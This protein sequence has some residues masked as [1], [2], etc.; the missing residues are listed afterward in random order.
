MLTRLLG[1]L[2]VVLGCFFA[3]YVFKGNR[4]DVMCRIYGWYFAKMIR[5]RPEKLGA[6]TSMGTL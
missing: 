4:F 6:Q 5:L 1:L 3:M 2:A